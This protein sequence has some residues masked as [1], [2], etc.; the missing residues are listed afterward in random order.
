MKNDFDAKLAVKESHINNNEIFNDSPVM[1]IFIHNNK[2]YLYDTYKNRLF[3]ISPEHYI[4]LQ[5]LSRIGISEYLRLKLNN[6]AYRDVIMLI[7][8]GMLRTG[9][10]RNVRHQE[11]GYL[12]SITN[13]AVSEITLQVTKNCN[14]QCRYCTFAVDNSITR[15][16]AGDN[17]TYEI[18]KES[19]DFLYN[20]SADATSVSVAFYGGEPTVNFKLI[21]QAV[22]Y[23]ENKFYS[24][25]V[26]YITTINGSNLTDDMICFFS[27]Y[28]F[29]LTISFDGAEDVQNMHRKYRNTGKGTFADVYKNIQRFRILRPEYFA[30]NVKFI[31][32]VLEDDERKAAK[33][34]FDEMGVNDDNLHISIADLHGVDYVKVKLESM[35]FGVDNRDNIAFLQAKRKKYIEENYNDFFMT[36]YNDK[37]SMPL[38]WHHNGPCVPTI[39]NLFVSTKGDFYICEKFLESEKFSIGNISTGLNM[40]KI[41]EYLNIG[42]IT[43]SECKSCWAMRFCNM[44]ALYCI[45]IETEKLSKSVKRISCHKTCEDV[46]NFFKEEIIELR[47]EK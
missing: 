41:E 26:K 33:D 47:G 25:S 23:A 31:S 36:Q 15:N 9:F 10:I 16:H 7:N 20:H 22:E 19:I 43:E 6:S 38:D 17:M 14:F 28:N 32:V 1:K 44:C 30:K 13:R 29:D 42:R 27:D 21:K 5:K 40:K 39:K 35:S 12:S 45:N 18:A 24:K 37:S 46:L 4:E 8:K 3:E 34:F 11:T 2:Y